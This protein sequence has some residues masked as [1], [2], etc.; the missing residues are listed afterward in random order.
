MAERSGE[1]RRQTIGEE[2]PARHP[3]RR[4]RRGR[5][6]GRHRRGEGRRR[7]RGRWEREVAGDGADEGG[8]VRARRG[9]RIES[10]PIQIGGE[11]GANVGGGKW[12]ASGEG[13]S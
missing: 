6:R 5:G 4:D 2:A 8:D 3:W 10:S 1:S 7:G 9:D 13:T 11:R 12:G